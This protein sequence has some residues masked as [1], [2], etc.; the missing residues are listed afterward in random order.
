MISPIYNLKGIV[1]ALLEWVKQDFD[2]FDNEEDS[3]LYQ[4]IHLGERDGDVEEFYCKR[5]FSSK[6]IIEK[7]VNR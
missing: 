1:Q 5:D 7:H 3:W 2:K 4:F 6:R